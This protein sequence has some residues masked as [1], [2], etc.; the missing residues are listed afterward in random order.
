[1]GFL[2]N[3]G[4]NALPPSE[5]LRK[6][7]SRRLKVWV[8]LMPCVAVLPALVLIFGGHV[9]VGLI[10]GIP[11]VLVGGWIAWL[12]FQRVTLITDERDSYKRPPD[13]PPRKLLPP[14]PPTNV[15]RRDRARRNKRR[16]H[17]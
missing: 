5:E 9:L 15:A 1:M 7:S 16:K 3:L 13:S 6:V 17:R 4:R 14:P 8:W 11:I 10:L 12:R 2:E